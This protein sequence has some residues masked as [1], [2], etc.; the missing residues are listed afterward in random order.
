[1]SRVSVAPPHS[2]GFDSQIIFGDLWRFE[3][4]RWHTVWLFSHHWN[5]FQDEPNLPLSHWVEARDG[6]LW[7]VVSL[8]EPHATA[9]CSDLDQNSP[10]MGSDVVRQG[11]PSAPQVLRLQLLHR[12]WDRQSTR[13]IPANCNN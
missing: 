11:T 2:H 12:L 10:K 6:L 5:V 13:R 4:C 9:L 1:M 8:H 3:R 7:T